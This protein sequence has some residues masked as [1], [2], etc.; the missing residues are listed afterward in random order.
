MLIDAFMPTYDL[1][2]RYHTDVRAPV[3]TVYETVRFPSS[4]SSVLIR[5]LFRLRGFSA[6]ALSLKGLPDA[7]FIL[8]GERQ[9]SEILLGLVGRFWTLSGHIQRLDR[10]G[11]RGFDRPGFAK[12]VVNFSL[13]LPAPGV[14]RVSTETRILCLCDHSR[15]RFH[16]YWALIGPFSGII[17]KE[18]LR[19]VKIRSEE[20][21]SRCTC[22]QAGRRGAK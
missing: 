5:T 10:E 3:E 21:H 16:L 20:S 22:R 2:T 18:W 8:L 9:N 17:R 7:G 14:T 4:G 19:I 13:S 15:R 11:F 6:D 12:A 1:R